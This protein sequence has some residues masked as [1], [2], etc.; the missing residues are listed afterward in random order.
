MPLKSHDVHT[1]E[2]ACMHSSSGQGQRKVV[3]LTCQEDSFIFCYLGPQLTVCLRNL[4]T[5]QNTTIYSTF[6]WIVILLH[7]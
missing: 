7:S 2:H 6:N 5:V 3:R 1:F 4:P